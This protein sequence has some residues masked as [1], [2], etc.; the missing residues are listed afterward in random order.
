MERVKEEERA[1]IARDL[2][3]DIGGALASVNFGIV[4][5]RKDVE[6]NSEGGRHL[7]L[8][9]EQ[10]TH[11]ANA[12]LRLMKE[13]RPSI[14]DA[15][16]APALEWHCREFQRRT[17]IDTTFSVNREE[18][19]FPSEVSTVAFRICQESLTNVMKHARATQA[20]VELF[21]DG[22]NLTLEVRDNGR[23]MS[24]SDL[25]KPTSFGVYGMQERAR[26][27]GGWLEVS[28]DT[29]GTSVMLSLPLNKS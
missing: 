8:L 4:S 24:P 20:H 10:V 1:A 19:H 2:H 21:T 9:Q 17:E 13:L 29:Q 12:V 18:I 23:G 15:G 16:L 7:E 26:S 14:L 27:L 22:E 3:D 25:K 6:S 11:A 28:S 5:L